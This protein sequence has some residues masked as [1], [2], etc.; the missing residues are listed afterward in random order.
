MNC[1][2]NFQATEGVVKQQH[3]QSSNPAISTTSK[4]NQRREPGGRLIRNILLNNDSRQSQSTAG[5]HKI[6]ILTSEN[7]K[8]LPRPFGSRSGLSDQ[9]SS[10]DAGQVNSE[11]DSKRD[12]S[13]KFVRRD[14]HG[15][16]IS[17]DKTE[18]RTRRPD[19]G[20]WAP[21]RR[22]D[23]SHPGNELPSSSSAQ[24]TLS[25]HESVEG[26]TKA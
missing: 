8:R 20:V 21:L 12:L 22:S 9:V 7:G 6:Q 15:L 13:E 4:Q 2:W 1:L 18:K 24:P 23:S 17:G 19:R 3:P 25:N 16:S 14:L 10:H 26:M 11:G 5:Q